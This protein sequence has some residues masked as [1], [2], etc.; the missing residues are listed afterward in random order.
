MKI[1]VDGL[2]TTRNL[3]Q[4]GASTGSAQTEYQCVK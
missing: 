2:A 1:K 3:L 4:A